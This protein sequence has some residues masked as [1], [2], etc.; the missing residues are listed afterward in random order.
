MDTW[1]RYWRNVRFGWPD[2]CWEWTGG[3]GKKDPKNPCPMFWHKGRNRVAARIGWELLYGPIPEQM[4]VCH[5]CDNRRCCNPLHWFLGTHLENMQDKVRKGR[6]VTP[7]G[8]KHWTHIHPDLVRRG[9]RSPQAKTEQAPVLEVRR[10]WA[11]GE[12]T[13]SQLG[14]R[15][16]M[17]RQCVRDIVTR[18]TWAWLAEEE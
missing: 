7:S 2:E 11:T 4:L 8:D 13:T 6:H 10:L 18:R 12:Y 14:R 5:T 9:E 16:G 15:F 17:S 1:E 3:S